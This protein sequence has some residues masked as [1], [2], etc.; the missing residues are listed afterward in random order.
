MGMSYTGSKA[1]F[2][3]KFTRSAFKK[4]DEIDPEAYNVS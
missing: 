3:R 2:E 1:A 4:V